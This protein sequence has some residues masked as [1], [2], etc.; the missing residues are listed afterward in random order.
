MGTKQ[1]FNFFIPEISQDEFEKSKQVII[2]ELGDW[3]T[4]KYWG[5]LNE[6]SCEDNPEKLFEEAESIPQAYYDFIN[7]SVR[8]VPLGYAEES[9]V[10]MSPVLATLCALYRK[11]SEKKL[12]FTTC[13]DERF[14]I[15]PS[16]ILDE[17]S[18]S[19]MPVEK[20]LAFEEMLVCNYMLKCIKKK[21]ELKNVEWRKECK[22]RFKDLGTELQQLRISMRNITERQIQRYKE[23]SGKPYQNIFCL[24]Q[25]KENMPYMTPDCFME[26]KIALMA[27]MA[28]SPILT[29]DEMS[30]D[31]RKT[32]DRIPRFFEKYT[33]LLNRL[34]E[35]NEVSI[36]YRKLVLY[37][38][39]LITAESFVHKASAIITSMAKGENYKRIAGIFS[40]LYCLPGIRLRLFYCDRLYDLFEESGRDLKKWIIY[41]NTL[42][43][44]AVREVEEANNIFYVLSN[45]F[46]EY[47]LFYSYYIAEVL[48]SKS[49][50]ECSRLKEYE[51]KYKE[52]KLQYDMTAEEAQQ[53]ALE[54]EKFSQLVKSDKMK[55]LRSEIIKPPNCISLKMIFSEHIEMIRIGKMMDSFVAEN[56]RNALI[57]GALPQRVKWTLRQKRCVVT[58]YAHC[59]KLLEGTDYVLGKKMTHENDNNKKEEFS[60]IEL[61]MPRILDFDMLKKCVKMVSENNC[62]RESIR[63]WQDLSDKI[64]KDS[65]EVLIRYIIWHGDG[66]EAEAEYRP[67]TQ[68]FIDFIIQENLRSAIE[69]SILYLYG[70]QR[71]HEFMIKKELSGAKTKQREKITFYKKLPRLLDVR[72]Y[73]DFRDHKI[74]RKKLWNTNIDYYQQHSWFNEI[75]SVRK[76]TDFVLDDFLEELVAA[77]LV[78]VTDFP[79]NRTGHSIGQ[80]I[81]NIEVVRRYKMDYYYMLKPNG[82]S[83][84]ENSYWDLLFYTGAVIEGSDFLEEAADFILPYIKNDNAKIVALYCQL[85][86]QIYSLP[87]I[88]IR[89]V[90]LEKTIGMIS[91]LDK[92]SISL[93]ECKAELI[94]YIDQIRCIL[95]VVST[96]MEEINKQ[97]I[98][99]KTILMEMDKSLKI[100]SER[101]VEDIKWD[102]KKVDVMDMMYRCINVALHDNDISL[103]SIIPK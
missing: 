2:S 51:L 46:Q 18:L 43:K 85:I 25:E 65:G 90:V 58:I 28:S 35:K 42:I 47:S 5:W 66:E 22:D 6:N 17:D 67:E 9:G 80:V 1:E 72:E 16:A 97:G 19:M 77:L 48:E 21:K 71:K 44:E 94:K 57:S 33:F 75:F 95:H 60:F 41:A 69:E 62:D 12:V 64:W 39:E 102:E 98:Y 32:Y 52:P 101:D 84:K 87:G 14:L 59:R 4:G 50:S 73:Y 40:S 100:E 13:D 86:P 36:V 78:S 103:H 34:L 11:Q 29:I 31:I 26:L 68:Y 23:E 96:V 81:E 83:K 45:G 92:D 89:R 37:L 3:L 88:K 93:D 7:E 53:R 38:S 82:K 55:E 99:N 70:I 8:K 15:P 74:T 27:C 30:T 56:N 79:L 24:W 49:E 20:R 54:L 76:E 63:S 61:F 10:L 91:R